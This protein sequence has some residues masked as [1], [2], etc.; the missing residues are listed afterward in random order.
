MLNFLKKHKKEIIRLAIFFACLILLSFL[1]LGILML[2]KVVT[3]DD[4][5]HFNQAIFDSLENSP[6]LYIVFLLLQ[7]VITTLLCFGPG[8]TLMF[9]MLGIALFGANYRCFLI[10]YSGMILSSIC[11]D[12]LGRF[13]GA[14]FIKFLIGEK[15]YD[16]A[17]N[18]M[19]EKGTVYLPFMYLLPIFPDNALC[20]IAGMVKIKFYLHVIYIILFRGLGIATIVFGINII[21]FERFTS[22]YDYLV[23]IAVALVY[24]FIIFK[25]ARY[26]DKA[27]MRYL[28]NK[29]DKEK[30]ID[31]QSK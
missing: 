1:I 20:L 24:L 7:I 16:E 26:I 3:Y 9:I 4:G 12:L 25:I 10:V 14:R 5:F 23:L 22:F 15:S 29:K 28:Q 30:E 27:Y 11:M 2:T 8:V 19:Q 21:P 17:Y 6:W 31:N 18:L 13:G